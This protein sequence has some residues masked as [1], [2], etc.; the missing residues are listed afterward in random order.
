MLGFYRRGIR[1]LNAILREPSFQFFEGVAISMG[2]MI[3]VEI[4][5]GRIL[6]AK[7]VVPPALQDV[8]VDELVQAIGA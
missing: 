3:P 8:V 1:D 5:D 2:W 4:N 6:L 7:S